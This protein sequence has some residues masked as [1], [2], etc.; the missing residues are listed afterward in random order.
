MENNKEINLKFDTIIELLGDKI[1]DTPFAALRENLQNAVDAIRIRNKIGHDKQASSIKI[2]IKNNVFDI[3]DT[4]I[5]MDRNDLEEYFWSIGSSGKK[6]HTDIC[7]GT[8][9]IGAF[10]NFGIAESITVISRKSIKDK[11]IKSFLSQNIINYTPNGKL[12]KV[13]YSFA[14]FEKSDDFGT[15]VKIELK[16]K[17]DIDS[18]INYIKEYAAGLDIY[19]SIN[20][21]VI[22]MKDILSIPESFAFRYKNT[23]NWE[24]FENSIHVE[25]EIFENSKSEIAV[26]FKSQNFVH[27]ILIPEKEP[28]IVYN[29]GFKLCHYVNKSH[30][31]YT[32]RVNS[33]YLKPT[34]GRDTLNKESADAFKEIENY[35]D[36]IIVSE[37]SISN[38]RLKNM[39][40]LFDY[41]YMKDKFEIFHK[42]IVNL[43]NRE[44][45]ILSDINKINNSTTTDIYYT[46]NITN[47]AKTLANKGNI[48]VLIN[49]SNYR[50]KYVISNYLEK[51]CSARSISEFDV[52]ENLIEKDRLDH[53]E[54]LL[55]EKIE[56]IFSTLIESSSK[57]IPAVLKENMIFHWQD[58]ANENQEILY[59]NPYH[60]DIVYLKDGLPDDLKP[61]I[62]T[63]IESLITNSLGDIIFK[64]RKKKNRGIDQIGIKALIESKYRIYN[65]SMID[66]QRLI[67][68]R[69]SISIGNSDIQTIH[70]VDNTSQLI[71]KILIIQNHEKYKENGCFIRLDDTGHKL[72]YPLRFSYESLII[73]WHYTSLSFSFSIGEY[74]LFHVVLDFD[75]TM[76]INDKMWG[77][78]DESRNPIFEK[79]STYLPIPYEVEDMVIPK[80][81]DHYITVIVR[82]KM[83][84]VEE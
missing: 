58:K 72:I 49:T 45:V 25:C 83:L 73:T 26:R 31:N 13:E 78:F 55:L 2:N 7:I 42:L 8:F 70:S 51:Y 76:C 19:V 11:W 16:N 34:A 84:L 9:G 43:I 82:S 1:Y 61:R 4:G 79:D 68:N 46:N 81:D 30:I 63:F 40:G 65:L 80:S 54:I 60:Q 62:N 3:L 17:I 36:K 75:N 35:L 77:E 50:E 44:N 15:Y 47:I 71:G 57:I 20:D 5:G 48:V 56:V 24:I 18:A 38:E 12:P 39:S 23:E 52:I 74:K 22:S 64:Y 41:A 10:A 28:S 6:N 66:I 29:H 53:N 69:R 14:D 21:S 32:L 27:G 59:C 67:S 33:R 37:A